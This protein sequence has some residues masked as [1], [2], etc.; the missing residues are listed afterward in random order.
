ML[1]DQLEHER[2]QLGAFAGTGSASSLLPYVG[3]QGV[4]LTDHDSSLGYAI[5]EVIAAGF[6]R[7]D[8]EFLHKLPWHN[9]NGHS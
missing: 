5:R 6:L 4:T 7:G 8:E 2:S 9:H 3:F 1:S